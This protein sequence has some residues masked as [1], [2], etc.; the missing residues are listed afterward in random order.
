MQLAIAYASKQTG[1]SGRGK[2]WQASG[3]LADHNVIML[4]SRQPGRL[5]LF[6]YY[7]ALLHHIVANA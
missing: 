7:D 2:W 4:T 1:K 6:T 3:W 5:L